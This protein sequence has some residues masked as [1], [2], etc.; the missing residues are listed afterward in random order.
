ME[1]N[2]IAGRGLA[3]TTG[4]I[5]IHHIHVGDGDDAD[6]GDDDD[7]ADDFIVLSSSALYW[8]RDT[9][10]TNEDMLQ[11]RVVCVKIKRGPEGSREQNIHHGNAMK[12]LSQNLVLQSTLSPRTWRGGPSKTSTLTYNLST[13]GNCPKLNCYR[14][15]S[16]PTTQGIHL[17]SPHWYMSIPVQSRTVGGTVRQRGYTCCPTVQSIHSV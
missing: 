2:S 12:A 14:I 13:L 3:S 4:T 9:K 6:H 5:P 8:G 10:Q 17:S 7:D 1:H 16:C 11:R 15:V